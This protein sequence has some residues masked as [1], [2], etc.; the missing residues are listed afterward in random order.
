MTKKKN[1]KTKRFKVRGLRLKGRGRDNGESFT[2]NVE[3]FLKFEEIK[4]K[5][6]PSRAF[7]STSTDSSRPSGS[8]CRERGSFS[9]WS[10]GARPF[11]R[12]PWLG[13]R[14]ARS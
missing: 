1:V 11:A 12:S 14:W 10:T 7:L 2:S 6:R 8:R 3:P 5:A 9:N 13:P 4:K